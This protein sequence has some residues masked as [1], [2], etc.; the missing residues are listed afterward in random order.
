MFTSTLDSWEV[1]CPHCGEL[2]NTYA[3][4]PGMELEPWVCKND[5][6]AVGTFNI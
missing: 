6:C 3:Q 2:T 4:F 1:E 5:E